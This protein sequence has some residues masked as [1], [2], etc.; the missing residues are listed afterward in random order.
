MILLNLEEITRK[1]LDKIKK[2]AMQVTFQ[3]SVKKNDADA[4]SHLG[5]KPYI[6]KDEKWPT[7]IS[8]K[9]DMDFFLQLREIDSDKNATLKTFYQCDCRIKEFTPFIAI[10]EYS[11]PDPDFIDHTLF[12]NKDFEDYSVIKLDPSWSAPS[13]SLLEAYNKSLYDEILKTF[14]NDD[15]QADAFYDEQRLFND[16]LPED[17]FTVLYGYPEFYSDPIHPIKC[18]CCNKYTQFYFQIDSMH[19]QNINWNDGTLYC[20]VCPI[21]KTYFF[22]V[23]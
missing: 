16:F 8:C 2:A 23:N 3:G 20:Y 15:E 11:N 13:W 10:R 21:T 9:E 22:L 7:C 6:L 17:P 12:E 14:E 19:K 18:S 1:E 5:G 4:D